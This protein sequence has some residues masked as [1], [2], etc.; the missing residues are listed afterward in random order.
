VFPD[1]NYLLDNRLT[2]ENQMEDILV[3]DDDSIMLQVIKR[4]LG[5]EGIVAHCVESG[6]EALEKIKERT[7]SLMITDFNMPGLDGLELTRKGLEI[8]PHM[9][10]IMGTGG[11]SPKIT[12]LAKEIGIS[13]VLTKPFRLNELLN[14]IRDVLGKRREW[15]ASTG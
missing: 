11:I 1:G 12:R 2:E 4:I 13:K 3:V 14:E 15:A 6:E 5:R 7:F 8:A 10:I 9:S